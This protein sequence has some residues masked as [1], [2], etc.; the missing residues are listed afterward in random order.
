MRELQKQKDILSAKNADN[1]RYMTQ[2]AECEKIH[3][4]ATAERTL[5]YRAEDFQI[6]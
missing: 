2:R 6:T 5:K 3:D 1:L 4:I